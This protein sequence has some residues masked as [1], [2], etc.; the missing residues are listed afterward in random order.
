MAPFAQSALQ[1]HAAVHDPLA[2]AN[3]TLDSS[4]VAGFFGGDTAVHGMATVNLFRWRKWGGWYNSPGSYEIA[5]KYGQLATG[6]ICKG[7]FPGGGTDDPSHLFGLNDKVGPK[8][9][10][11]RSGSSFE[12][13]GHLAALIMRMARSTKYRAV[14]SG[15]AERITTPATVTVVD[16]LAVPDEIV[17]PELSHH[18][19]ALLAVV[20][21]GASIG[22]CVG[23][24]LIADWWS[25]SSIL[26][27]MFANGCACFVL[28]S[29]K[30]TFKHHKPATGAPRGD[31]IFVSHNSGVVVIRGEEGAVNCLT[32]GRFYLEYEKPPPP[33]STTEQPNDEP[34]KGPTSVNRDPTF[35]E[36]P[37][38]SEDIEKGPRRADGDKEGDGQGK[39]GEE[40]EDEGQGDPE[41]DSAPPGGQ[42]NS[43]GIG[44]CSILLTAQ[45]LV[46]LL[47]IPQG[48][49]FGQVMF[50]STLAVSW[51]YNTYL[52]S[53]NREDI[54]TTIL[55]KILDLKEA[56]VR[57]FEFGTWTA[58]ST[59]ACLA[60]QRDGPLPNDSS[61]VW[62][63]LLPRT[64]EVW[65]KWR[66]LVNAKLHLSTPWN[67]EPSEYTVGVGLAGKGKLFGDAD[68]KL[69]GE[70]LGD[71]QVAR[72]RYLKEYGAQ[73]SDLR[74]LK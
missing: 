48:V 40:K 34:M 38:D 9:L 30:L 18:H 33:E 51:G 46:Q 14:R 13:T 57:K 65:E 5:K 53:I 26:L 20:P 66:T 60:L 22:A 21:V 67:F 7:L 10:A 24:A 32:R 44:L 3:F 47:L 72:S 58:M 69:L 16:L 52:S 70:L 56:N 71:A 27:G 36:D 39:D 54:Q 45:F 59:F 4:G 41:T 61:M 42:P 6:R 1:P 15:G 64:T 25:F 37:S 29:G 31:G 62:D 11:T 73:E 63:A 28:G 12:R 23:C 35:A 19:S 43:F 49:L 55:R 74:A 2:A 68:L 17:Y 8:F 50:V